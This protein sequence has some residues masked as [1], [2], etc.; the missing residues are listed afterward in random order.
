[1]NPYFYSDTISNFLA[2]SANV[3]FGTI[4]CNSDFRGEVTQKGAWTEEIRI[5]KEA[6]ED[7]E[8]KFFFLN[9][10]PGSQNV[11][12]VFRCPSRS[13][14]DNLSTAIV[15]GNVIFKNPFEYFGIFIFGM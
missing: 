14:V 10:H 8:S 9:I 7:Q 2:S 11:P 5:L 6:P 1:M 13:S 15:A 12:A 4:T 3:I